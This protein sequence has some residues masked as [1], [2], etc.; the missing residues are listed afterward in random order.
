MMKIALAQINTT[1]GDIPANVDKIIKF[2]QEA[3]KQHADL[4]VFPELAITG[5]PP[6]DLLLKENFIQ[7]NLAALQEIKKFLGKINLSAILGFVDTNPGRGKHLFNACAFIT[8]GEISSKQ[9]KT[10]LPTYDVFDED[11]YF[12]P[13]DTY[14]LADFNKYK[15]GMTICEDAWAAEE[16]DF[17]LFHGSA[18]MNGRY[19]IDPIKEVK[20]LGP[21]FIVNIAASPFSIDKHNIRQNIMFGHANRWKCPIFFVNQV[22]GNDELVFDGRSFVVDTAGNIVA[23][24]KSFEEDLLFVEIELDG[25]TKN[26]TI[27]PEEECLEIYKALVLGTRD[28]VKK[29]GFSDVLIGLSGGIDSAVAAAIA[30]AALGPEHVLGICMPSPYSSIES[31]TD[32][33]RLAKN[34][35]MAVQIIPIR[36]SMEVLDS[37]LAASFSGM[38]RDVTEENLQARLRGM[39]LMALSNKYKKMLLSTG[40][41]S[42]LAVGYCTLYGDMC[43][44]LAVISDL[45]KT[46]VYKLAHVIN[47]IAAKEI[48]PETIISKAPSAELSPGQKDEDTLPPYAVLDVILE[49]YIEKGQAV[50]QII[51]SG[52]D[53]ATV[54]KIVQMVESNEFKRRQAA[55]G[56]KLTSRAFGLGWKMP[57]AQRYRESIRKKQ[58][59]LS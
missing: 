45:L 51:K 41:K 42:E 26:G 21:D 54:K 30:C 24:A 35:G 46:R 15:I 13:A 10:L 31:V 44:G 1:I 5:Y 57:I 39:I 17:T 43:G 8:E 38:S 37:A 14:V 55:P 6:A 16:A 11:R 36:Q 27:E 47:D 56:L 29:C 7:D 48:I 52:Q 59:S 19:F 2:A 22:G 20:K 53:P 12:Q 32:S 25:R 18:A 4:I 3:K 49:S 40:N 33:E 58:F 9:Y 23:S 34:L 28:Y 50:G